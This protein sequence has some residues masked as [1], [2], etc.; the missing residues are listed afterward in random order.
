MSN[1]RTDLD[2]HKLIRWFISL[3]NEEKNRF[4]L[5]ITKIKTMI[6]RQN[7]AIFITNIEKKDKAVLFRI[8]I[9]LFVYICVCL[10]VCNIL[11]SS[12]IQ[13]F[14]FFR[15]RIVVVVVVSIMALS[16][17]EVAHT[18]KKKKIIAKSDV[19]LSVGR[20]VGWLPHWKIDTNKWTKTQKTFLFST[21]YHYRV[22]FFF[23]IVVVMP[24][25]KKW[26]LFG[27]L[28]FWYTN[29][30]IKFHFIFFF[31]G[32]ELH[33]SLSPF[34]SVVTFKRWATR[35]VFQN[36][37]HL[38]FYRAGRITVRDLLMPTNKE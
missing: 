28:Q 5:T 8:L 1:W 35:T 33:F 11:D 29:A 6:N 38:C 36:Q 32:P 20:F 18:K 25:W 17:W 16:N 26:I 19:H 24:S 23:A 2:L 15:F 9:R 31:L 27:N 7:K 12:S 10:C 21:V 3:K 37:I 4:F 30:C 34:P 13:P 22:A 14:F